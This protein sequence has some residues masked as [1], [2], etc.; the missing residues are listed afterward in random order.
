MLNMETLSDGF[1]PIADTLLSG[2]LMLN[3]APCPTTDLGRIG[4]VVT[5]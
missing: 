3:T 1:A 4:K 2:S 5:M